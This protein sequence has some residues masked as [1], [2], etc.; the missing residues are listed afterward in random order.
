MSEHTRLLVRV[1][2]QITWLLGREMMQ[3]FQFAAKQKPKDGAVF[4]AENYVPNL[5]GKNVILSMF[6]RMCRVQRLS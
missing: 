6:I 3:K 1:D 4:S 2:T 5:E